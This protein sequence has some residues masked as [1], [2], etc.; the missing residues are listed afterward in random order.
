MIYLVITI[1]LDIIFSL[2]IP[3]NSLFL[4]LFFVSSLPFLYMIFSKKS[5]YII[6]VIVGFIYD[7][8]YSD[9]MFLYVLVFLILG[10]VTMMIYKRE[11]LSI[12]F[13]FIVNVVLY[14]LICF[15]LYFVFGLTN[16]DY[17]F[18]SILGSSFILNIIYIFISMF[19][20]K[21][22]IFFTRKKLNY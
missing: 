8:F 19:V 15:T 13:T 3:S 12:L 17:R 16:F 4:P 11:V 1:F 7:L 21:S 22:H 20:L 9:L 14:Y 18:L 5:Y 2:I 6:L 10:F